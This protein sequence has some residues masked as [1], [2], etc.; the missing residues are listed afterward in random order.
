MLRRRSREFSEGVLLLMVKC[1]DE[2]IK[3]SKHI[4][5]FTKNFYWRNNSILSVIRPI[6]T[7]V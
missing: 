4:Y 6:P 5:I 2:I 3:L 1:F 7:N